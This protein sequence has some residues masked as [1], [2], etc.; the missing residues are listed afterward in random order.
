MTLND[1]KRDFTQN[2]DEPTFPPGW[3]VCLGWTILTS[4][5]FISFIIIICQMV[6]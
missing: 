4:L 2:D 3:I 5:V 6:R 1:D